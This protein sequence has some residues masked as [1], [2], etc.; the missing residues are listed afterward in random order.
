MVHY[1][2]LARR[3]CNGLPL[4]DGR[5]DFYLANRE[6]KPVWMTGDAYNDDQIIELFEATRQRLRDDRDPTVTFSRFLDRIQPK[7]DDAGPSRIHSS[8]QTSTARFRNRLRGYVQASAK[9]KFRFGL[10]ATG[11]QATFTVYLRGDES[12][13]RQEI[14]PRPQVESDDVAWDEIV[15]ELPKAGEYRV[16][17][18]GDCMLRMPVD[19]PFVFEA[20]TTH[21]AWI[22]YS[23]PHYFYVPRGTKE[24]IV[25]AQPKVGLVPPGAK[26]KIEVTSATRS[27]DGPYT[28]VPVPLGTDGRVWHTSSDTRGQVMF[29]NVPPLLSFHRGTILVPREV[30][31][32]TRSEFHGRRSQRSQIDSRLLHL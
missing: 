13:V 2:A 11:R 8:D 15:V 17:I 16:E 9:Q 23:G 27:T 32:P 25:D 20:S 30:V 31:D 21:P 28:V 5:R 26:S 4:Q 19:M 22:D 29:L 14:K 12:L 18:I 3:L 10:A 24:L 6:A 7:G 1:Y